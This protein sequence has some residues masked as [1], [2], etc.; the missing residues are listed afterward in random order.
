MAGM[1][2]DDFLLSE[3]MAGNERAFDKVF[4]SCYANLCRF[5]NTI[6]HDEDLAQSLV[7]NVFVKLWEKRETLGNVNHLQRYLISMVRNESI[8]YIN[9]EKR[10]V[11]LG[12]IPEEQVAPVADVIIK[13]GEFSERLVL[14]LSELPERCREAFEYSRYDQLTN[15]EIAGKMGISQK[16]VEA[17]ITR[18]LKQIREKLREFL[19]SGRNLK[20]PGDLLFLFMRKVKRI[21]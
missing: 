21:F 3:L 5:S 17:L 20:L 9:R 16:A 11:R 10:N 1:P 6:V 19:P 2:L 7:Q 15:R 8:N 4:H 13:E 18:S 14:A 12:E